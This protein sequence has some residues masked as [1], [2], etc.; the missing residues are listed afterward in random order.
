MGQTEEW[1]DRGK[2]ISELAGISIEF[3]QSEKEGV[4]NK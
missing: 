4:G 1:N 3:I 2:K